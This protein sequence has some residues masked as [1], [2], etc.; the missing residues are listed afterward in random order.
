[1]TRAFGC[2]FLGGAVNVL[3]DGW[4]AGLVIT[5]GLILILNSYGR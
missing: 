4:Y 3:T 2:G 1:M 5:V